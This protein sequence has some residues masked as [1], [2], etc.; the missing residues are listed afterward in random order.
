MYSSQLKYVDVSILST[1]AGIIESNPSV[2]ITVA[3]SRG[4]TTY[5][6]RMLKYLSHKYKNRWSVKWNSQWS[7]Q[8]F[9]MSEHDLVIWPITRDG[10]SIIGTTALCLGTPV[11]AWN[12]PPI[13]ECLS[14]DNSVLVGCDLEY[15]WL[16]MPEAKQDYMAFERS[17]RYLISSN[18]LLGK[19]RK[20]TKDDLLERKEVFNSSLDMILNNT[21]VRHR[22]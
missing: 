6:V 19:L 21:H 13:N 15:N 17:L 16:G 20:H 9:M 12:V 2:T 8:V 14:N 1:L 4:L 22:W 3:C 7:E 5:A 11:M 18:T 10:F